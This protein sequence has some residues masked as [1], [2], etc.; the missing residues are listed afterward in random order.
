MEFK[1]LPLTI[2][3]DTISPG[4][5]ISYYHEHKRELEEKLINSGA[6]KFAG[7]QIDSLDDFQQIVNSISSRFFNYV[8]GNSPRIKLS[9]N[10]YTSTEYDKRQK[11]T[12]HNE[13][14]YSAKWPNKLFFSCIQPAETGG[15]TLIADSRVI[16]HKINKDIVSEIEQKGIVY[17]R[18]LHGGMGVG[19]SWQDTFE[20][21]DKNVLEEYCKVCAIEFEWGENDNLRLKQRSKGIH[22]HRVTGEK[23]WFNQ[24]D[25]FH[26]VHLG[27]QLYTE[28][29]TLYSPDE[30]PMYVTFG[31]GSRIGESMV[32]EILTT[33]EEVTIAPVWNK[34]ELLIIDN[35]LFSHGRNPYTGERKVLVAMSE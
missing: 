1:E 11:I 20:T 8:D 4:D 27:E 26:P 31:D 29:L 9:G 19:P 35:E 7:I 25:Q 32:K 28:L 23:V 13:L 12:M 18:N 14:S 5:F 16:L 30:F 6:I 21:N 17:I 2:R 34:N 3:L 22:E 24:I 15:E 33:I 10:V